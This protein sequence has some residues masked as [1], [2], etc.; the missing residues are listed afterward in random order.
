MGPRPFGRGNARCQSCPQRCTADLQWGR[1]LSV[2]EIRN[3][4]PRRD[5]RTIPSMGP[6][7]FGRGNV[8]FQRQAA[9]GPGAFNGAAA[10]RSRKFS[11]LHFTHRGISSLQWGRGLSVAEMR[12]ARL[13]STGGIAPSMGPRPFGRGNVGTVYTVS[14]MRRLQWGRGLSVAEISTSRA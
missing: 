11:V 6:R 12:R 10:F 5:G 7:P 9:A 2:A 4:R 13:V 3:G 1:G 14:E 8:L